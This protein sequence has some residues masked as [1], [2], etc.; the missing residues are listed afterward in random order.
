MISDPRL[1]L[2]VHTL[3]IA[4][5]WSRKNIQQYKDS[6]RWS[7]SAVLSV[8]LCSVLNRRARVIILLNIK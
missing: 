2:C 4:K 6:F 8:E 1:V 7:V 5:V 3:K